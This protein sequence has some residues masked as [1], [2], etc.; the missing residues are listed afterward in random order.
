MECACCER[1]DKAFAYSLGAL[2]AY[3]DSAILLL[4]M[5]TKVAGQMRFQISSLEIQS[6]ND[7]F[8]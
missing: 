8:E 1:Q 7:A 2:H 4:A 5:P 3:A 6:T